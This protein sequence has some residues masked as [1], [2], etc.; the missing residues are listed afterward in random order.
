MK[1]EIA[2]EFL[3]LLENQVRY[4]AY[5]KPL[6]AK[7]FK[8]D[9]LLNIKKDLIHPFHFKKS[10][11]Y[12]DEKIRVYVFKDYTS[13]YKFDIENQIVTVFGFIKHKETL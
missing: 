12:N 13:V 8:K 4:I 2:S 10:I 6:A 1:I 11:Y 3:F 7:K 9:L 5:D